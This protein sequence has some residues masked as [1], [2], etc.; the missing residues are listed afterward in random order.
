MK[1]HLRNLLTAVL[2]T[3][4]AC[5]ATAQTAWR[6]FASAPNA[7]ADYRKSVE[8]MEQGDY[9]Q[10][11]R[12]LKNISSD[13]GEL[14]G[15][16]A[17]L[18]LARL[19]KT[20]GNAWNQLGNKHQME[21]VTSRM[22]YMINEGKQLGLLND[23][24]LEI[25]TADTRKLQGNILYEEAD[26]DIGAME[27]AQDYFSEAITIYD[28][29]SQDK[30]RA[31][32]QMELA[33]LLYKGKRY[34]D[35]IILLDAVCDDYEA[36]AADE[37]IDANLLYDA[38]SARAMCLARLNRFDEALS[39]IERGVKQYDTK[40]G[41]RYAEM[42]R[43]KA[44]ILMLRQEAT[45]GPK[46]EALKCYKQAFDYQKDYA[47]AHL[48][49]M[50]DAER[51]Q[52]WMRMRPFIA[53]CYRLEDADAAFLFDVTLFSKGLLLQLSQMTDKGKT[54][55][56]AIASLRH[57]W[58]QI[59]KKLPKDGC[60]IEFVQ[61]E[62]QDEQQMGAL[63]VHKSGRPAFVKLT[64]PED[65]MEHKIGAF[66]VRQRLA[67]EPN[68]LNQLYNDTTELQAKIWPATLIS[69]IGK[70]K[71]V[72]F[73]P[74]GY[75]NR[76]AIEYMLPIQLGDIDIYRLTST[77]TLLSARPLTDNQR[78]LICGG[79][80]YEA[81]TTISPRGDQRGAS[82]DL[83]TFDY[84]AGK[85][86]KFTYLPGSL[87]EA[88]S[89]MARRNMKGDLLITGSDVTEQRFCELASQYPIINIST[90]GF[91]GAATTPLGTDLK[92]CL[93]DESMSENFLVLAGANTNINNEDFDKQQR[94]GLLSAL[95]MSALDLSQVELFVASAC[96]SG[97]G[98]ITADGVYGIQRGLK[99][100]GVSAMVVSLFNVSDK[101]T[102]IM[103]SNFQTL[104]AHGMPL[105]KAFF[106]AR[107]TLK[108]PTQQTKTY[109]DDTVMS[110][111]VQ[112]NGDFDLPQYTNAFIIIDAIDN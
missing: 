2:M 90:H 10:A 24:E 14:E 11:A 94:D 4:A 51:E 56:E 107:E 80:T 106:A 43:K 101:A 87:A 68:R 77:R 25:L 99:N 45:G 79:I 61:Y 34:D 35:A 41:W 15:R 91:F 84:A 62:K 1:R 37:Y 38:L 53:D 5:G 81:T 21:R 20:E 71:K 26:T 64:K 95:E 57:T 105:H 50:N 85:H 60:A 46:D 39:N 93:T 9:L 70:D 12:L 18:D 63:I 36:W 89:I 103:L 23:N 78:A 65:I 13:I 29:M 66:T 76:I 88:D 6:G 86:M 8:M 27:Q 47:L 49:T 108:T 111:M 96:Q 110:S 42:L 48:A 75:Q 98:H 72:Y 52:F 83:R 100:A 22:S 28:M 7:D 40:K 30:D 73:S 92:P 102:S 31:V 32:S 74:A 55:T 104:V 16:Q 69:A 33:E 59:Q 58:Q 44:K 109:L 19:L 3:A 97:S 82:N 17:F 54:G 67:G 112:R